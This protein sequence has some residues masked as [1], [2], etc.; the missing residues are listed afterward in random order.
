MEPG[1]CVRTLLDSTLDL[2][3]IDQSGVDDPF[4][5]LSAGKFSQDDVA[6][7]LRE[8]LVELI[9]MEVELP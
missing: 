6:R 7:L 3:G 8:V 9:G 2:L 5:S 1:L 4:R